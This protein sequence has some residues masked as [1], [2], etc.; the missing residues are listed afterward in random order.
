RSL[1]GRTNL[2]VWRLR[3]LIWH[4]QRHRD[5]MVDHVALNLARHILGELT[6]T[7]LGE[8]H[9]IAG[10]QAADLALIVWPLRREAAALVHEAVPDVDV[11]DTGLI[12]AAAVDLVEIGGIGASLGAALRGQADPDHGGTGALERRDGGVYALDVGN[13]PLLGMEFP[14]TIR[15]DAQLIRCEVCWR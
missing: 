4:R 2:R 11:G 8:I 14:R 15:R 13:L 6:G 5:R 9:S 1:D 12:R 7:T 10:T 3:S